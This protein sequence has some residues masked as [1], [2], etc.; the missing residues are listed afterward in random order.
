MR[1]RGFDRSPTM[2]T[3]KWRNLLK[4]FK[5]AK[6]SDR[7]GSGK[8][9]CYKEI[10]EILGER[11]TSVGDYKSPM[12]SKVDSYMHFSDKDGE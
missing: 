5:K 12:A 9:W 10:E 2:C 7:A 11:S 8:M 3:D 6:Q 1:G 4:E